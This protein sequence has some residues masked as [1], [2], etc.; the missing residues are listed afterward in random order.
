MGKHIIKLVAETK[1]YLWGGN[2]LRNYGKVSDKDKIAESW[3]LSYH[4]DGP[5]KT[6]NGELLSSVL[7]PSDL[8]KNVNDFEDFPVLVKLIDSADFL[9]VQVHPSDDYALKNEG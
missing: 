3:E 8:G 5:S 6:V 7:M 1:D 9:S 4:K 2:K